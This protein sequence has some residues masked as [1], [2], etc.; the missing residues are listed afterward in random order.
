MSTIRIG[1]KTVPLESLSKEEKADAWSK[2]SKRITDTF[3]EYMNRHPE[4]KASI[5]AIEE[6][7]KATQ[8]AK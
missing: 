1:D 7:M 4:D 8:T 6:W 5:A 3:T 2:I